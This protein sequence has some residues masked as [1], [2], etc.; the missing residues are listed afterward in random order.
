MV[1]D[2]NI[3][4]HPG[5]PPDLVADWY[6]YFFDDGVPG[7]WIWTELREPDGSGPFRALLIIFPRVGLPSAENNRLQQRGGELAHIYT[8]HQPNPMGWALPGPINGWDGNEDE[9][10]LKPSIF[11]RGKSKVK[12]WHGFFQKGKLV[13]LDGSIVGA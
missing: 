3:V 12:G 1:P 5:S 10:T 4:H 13:N 2:S 9:P 8:S 7:D 11:I 6:D